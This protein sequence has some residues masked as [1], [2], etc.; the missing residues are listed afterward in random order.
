MDANPLT[1]PLSRCGARSLL[2]GL[3][4]VGCAA[5]QPTAPPPKRADATAAAPASSPTPAAGIPKEKVDAYARLLHDAA[6]ALQRNDN[7]GALRLLADAKQLLPAEA[8]AYLG[9]GLLFYQMGRASAA[10]PEFKRA[11]ELAEPPL[12]PGILRQVEE[13]TARPKTAEEDALLHRAFDA[14]EGGHADQALPVLQQAL[15]LNPL[16]ARTRY[17]IGY[18]MI[19]LGRI[20]DAIA[21]LEEGRRINPVFGKLLGELQY[22]YADRRRSAEMR[23]VVSDRILVEGEQPGLLQELGYAYAASGDEDL[24]ITTLEENLRRFPAFYPSH[25]SLAQLYCKRR[26]DAPR[27]REHLATFMVGLRRD[28]AKPRDA[29]GRLLEEPKLSQLLRDAQALQASCGP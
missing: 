19:S 1:S 3:A 15:D 7:D 24:A 8:P 27:G 6:Q 25:F 10:A 17:E 2:A 13:T 14:T 9:A 20:D 11:V 5:A 21:Q 22:C 12:K 4:L 18:A 26:R 29:E 28:Q 23:G 16:N